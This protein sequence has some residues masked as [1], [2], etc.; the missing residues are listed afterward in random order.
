LF[1][2]FNISWAFAQVNPFLFDTLEIVNSK[3]NK[4]EMVIHIPE[5]EENIQLPVLVWLHGKGER[6][7]P[8]GRQTGNGLQHLMVAMEKFNFKAILIA[9]HCPANDFWSSYDKL[10]DTITMVKETQISENFM[11]YFQDFLKRTEY[12]IDKKR[13]YIA[14]ISMGG[15]GTWDWAMRY[16][17]IFAAAIPMC[18]GG[19]PRKHSKLSKLPVWAFHGE[20]DKV[21]K[22]QFTKQMEDELKKYPI[23]HF[24]YYPKVGH[25]VWNYVFTND[26][27]VKWLFIQKK[28]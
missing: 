12:N 10:A 11:L 17:E 21:I 20:A 2:L 16:P 13:I 14:G 25:D 6:D 28:E 27:V 24:T 19:D 22:P 1:F 15:F 8:N 26:E 18:G 3:G 4:V 23:H 7:L 5:V 9:P